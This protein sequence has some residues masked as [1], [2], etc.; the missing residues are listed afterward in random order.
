MTA[1]AFHLYGTGTAEAAPILLQAGALSA[2]LVNGNLR[3]IRHGGSEV[4]RAIAYVVR[5]RDWGTYEPVLTDLT[6]DQRDGG[7]R[8]S[9]AA[10]C[11]GPGGSRLGFRTTIEGSADGNLS[12]DVTALPESDFETNRCGFCI[13]HPIAG[14]A[15]SAVT[16]EH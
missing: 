1:D 9:Y 4:L 14:L 15:G 10:S 6:I 5:D 16:V 12:F 3:T 7:F 2:E 13:L 8:V 11:A